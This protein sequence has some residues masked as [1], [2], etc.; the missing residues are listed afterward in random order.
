M[1]FSNEKIIFEIPIY[2]M[3]KSVFDEKWAQWKSKWYEMMKQRG[4]NQDEINETMSLIMRD[5]D[6]RN[7]WKYNQ[8]VGFVEVSITSRDIVFNE[9]R[10]LDKKIRAITNKKR[11]IQDLHTIGKHFPIGNLE[12]EELVSNIDEYITSIKNEL[13]GKMCLDLETYEI[14]KHHIDFIGIHKELFENE[15]L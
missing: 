3:P 14:V 12:N 2:S 10:T 6:Q 8:I 11:F 9:C 7:I 5:Q 13:P 1:L 15:N 4:R